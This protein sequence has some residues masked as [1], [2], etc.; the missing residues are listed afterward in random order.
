MTHPTV[1]APA[2]DAFGRALRAHREAARISQS[3]LAK[4]SRFDH[5]YVS[6]LETGGRRPTRDAVDR[7]SEAL[8]LGARESRQLMSAAGYLPEGA[9]ADLH[10]TAVALHRFLR[11]PD[12]PEA[13]ALAV[14]R[15]VAGLIARQ[16][17]S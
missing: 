13:Y 2:R 9:I 4:R 3:T 14:H 10:P 8:D 7:F 5:S 11:D 16:A 1:Y 15:A 12:L 6:R 17:P